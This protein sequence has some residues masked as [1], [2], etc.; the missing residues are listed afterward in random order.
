MSIKELVALRERQS[1]I[2][3]Q[4]K[5]VE[6]QLKIEVEQHGPIEGFGLRAHFKP[7]RKSTNHEA[8][9]KAANA[10]QALIDEH[11]TT[12]TTVQWAEVTKAAKVDLVL[13]TA[14]G[15][16]SFVVESV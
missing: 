9:A 5:Q 1:A 8:A 11:S 15:E 7:G 3:E 6:V 4:I 10:S 2:Q 13:F 14:Q 12:K 16:P